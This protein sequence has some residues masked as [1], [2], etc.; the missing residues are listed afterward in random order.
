MFSLIGLIL[1]SPLVMGGLL[2]YALGAISWI[3]VLRRMDLSYAYPFLALNFVLIA[4]V[5]Q[6]VLGE[7]VP[8]IRWVGIAAICAGI[9]LIAN[10][11]VGQ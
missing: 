5:G 4:L 2:L 11:G 3:A 8:W 10:G 6:F 7:P 9:L 1:R